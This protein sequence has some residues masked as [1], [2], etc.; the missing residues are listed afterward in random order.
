MTDLK[1]IYEDM[2]EAT[3]PLDRG[4]WW[5]LYPGDPESPMT[6]NTGDL[7]SRRAYDQLYARPPVLTPTGLRI[8]QLADSIELP[9]PPMWGR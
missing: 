1:R 5:Q 4:P 7:M 9:R 8:E 2:L 3:R 6:N